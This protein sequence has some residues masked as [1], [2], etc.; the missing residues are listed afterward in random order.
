MKNYL[1]LMLLSSIIILCGSV[2]QAQTCATQP[3]C[4]ELGYT[5]TSTTD[6]IGT[7]LKCPFDKTKYYCTTKTEALNKLSADIVTAAMPDYSKR[8]SRSN[9]TTYTAATNGFIV[10]FDGQMADAG[11]CYDCNSTNINI[12]INGVNVRYDTAQTNWARNSWSYPVKKGST[13]NVSGGNGKIAMGYFFV[14]TI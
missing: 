10:G 5:L 14:P 9:N 11:N 4:A 12:S 2:V 8:L 3:T 13:Y 6:C 1:K 7:V